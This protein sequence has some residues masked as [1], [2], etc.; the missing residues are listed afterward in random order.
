MRIQ[1]MHQYQNRRYLYAV[2]DAARLHIDVR[3]QCVDM[4]TVV[5]SRVVYLK[6]ALYYHI[7]R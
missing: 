1:T 2:D 7:E 3:V 5:P 6:V 4:R